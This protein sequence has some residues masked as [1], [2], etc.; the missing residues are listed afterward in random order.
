VDAFA[1]LP[2]APTAACTACFVAL[3]GADFSTARFKSSYGE[4]HQTHYWFDAMTMAASSKK[5]R[6]NKKSV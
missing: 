3:G 2:T 4:I 5:R 1:V 6:N